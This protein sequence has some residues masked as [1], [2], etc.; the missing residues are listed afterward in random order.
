[1]FSFN[2]KYTILIQTHQI[3]IE[4]NILL[5]EKL[6]FIEFLLIRFGTTLLRNFKKSKEFISLMFNTLLHN[7]S[8]L[9]GVL[10]K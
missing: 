1:M 9:K 3:Q 8:G 4:N 7:I 10:R 5:I 2:K 6:N